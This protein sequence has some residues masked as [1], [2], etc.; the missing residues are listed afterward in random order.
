MTIIAW[1]GRYVAADGLATSHS[2]RCL[3]PA[4][5][6]IVEDGLVF[7]FCGS[8]ALHAEMLSWFRA[9]KKA[10]DMPKCS[11]SNNSVLF[12]FDGGPAARFYKTELPYVEEQEPPFAWGYGAEFAIGAMDA[13]KGAAEAVEIAI[14]RNVWLGGPVQ[15]IDL[16]ELR[17][18]EIAA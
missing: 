5:K 15:V 18:Q 4:K 10:D 8:L 3:H 6:L 11:E 16:H 14:K 9:G 1:D 17:R 12:V 7:G 13:G 2:T